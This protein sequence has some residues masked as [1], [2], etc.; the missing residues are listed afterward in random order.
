MTMLRS[1]GRAHGPSGQDGERIPLALGQQLLWFLEHLYPGAA[2]GPAF[3]MRRRCR[4]RGPLDLGQLQRA[5]DVLVA[6]HDSLRSFIHADAGIPSQTVAPSAKVE[7]ASVDLTEVGEDAEAIGAF[8][9]EREVRDR[10]LLEPP[11]VWP[12]VARLGRDDHLLSVVVHHSVCDAWSMGVLMAELGE[13]YAAGLRGAEATLPPPQRFS[14]FVRAEQGLDEAS[15]RP[16]LDYWRRTLEAAEPTGLEVSMGPSDAD[17]DEGRC[18]WFDLGTQRA[19]A[20]VSA[21]RERR[22][23]PFI[24]LL[25]AYYLLLHA[26]TGTEDLTVP[27]FLSQRGKDVERLVGFLMNVLLL[28]TSVDPDMTLQA[29]VERTRNATLE[30]FAHHVPMALV[31][32]DVPDVGMLLADE[33]CLVAPFQYVPEPAAARPSAFGDTSTI[34]MWQP[35]AEHLDVP[36]RPVDALVTVRAWE[37]SMLGAIECPARAL[38]AEEITRIASAFC[39]A[40]DWIVARPDASAAAAAD[41]LRRLHP[42]RS[43]S[44]TE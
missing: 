1:D 6:R 4:V 26:L 30:A 5:F 40:V 22:A 14:D 13:I 34:E 2:L 37:G 18:H 21:A 38:S 3:T 8:F 44:V 12:A 43:Q 39:T 9:R 29:L 7:L 15:F 17:G 33:R 11:L 23:T 31:A 41:E 27:T 35:G 10:E 19:G 24:L 42:R 25:S 16:H 36:A 28:R 32:D 20:V